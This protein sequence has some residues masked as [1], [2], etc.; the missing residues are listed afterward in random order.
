LIILRDY[1]IK[2]EFL[3]EFSR[4][5]LGNTGCVIQDRTQTEIFSGITSLLEMK[6]SSTKVASYKNTSQI[7]HMR[8]AFIT[9]LENLFGG[10]I[11]LFWVYFYFL[12]KKKPN[13]AP[14]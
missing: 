1:H 5:F 14:S 3:A 4:L 12:G 10:R 9:K 2:R 6:D 7:C 11:G 8:V 13:F